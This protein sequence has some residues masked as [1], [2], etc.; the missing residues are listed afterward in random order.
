MMDVGVTKT[1]L[2]SDVVTGAI[3]SVPCMEDTWDVGVAPG[4]VW[5]A[6]L[7][8]RD[9]GELDDEGPE[10]DIMLDTLNAADEEEDADVIEE[11]FNED[12]DNGAT[13]SAPCVEDTW[14]V[15]VAPGNVW[16]VALCWRDD[17]ELD[18]EGP[19]EDIMLDT[20][21]A[22]DEEEDAD[23]IEEVF[24]EDVDDDNGATLSAPCVEDTW[25]VWVAPGNVWDVALCWRDDG[26]LD[27]E[28][29]EEDIML[30]TLNAADEEEDADVIEEMM[31][32]M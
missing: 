29:P 27:D 3:L 10:D 18:D 32:K 5:A 21:N 22:A 17:G 19:E 16:D 11:V 24:N 7:C 28:G 1:A 14:D 9:D 4:N 6:A 20:L 26:E 25:D 12:V 30:D 2:N 31:M 8:W 15:W 23:V 13:L